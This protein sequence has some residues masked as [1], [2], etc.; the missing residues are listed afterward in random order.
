MTAQSVEMF[1][2]LHD[3][4]ETGGGKN[5]QITLSKDMEDL[6]DEIKKVAPDVYASI[7]EIVIDGLY[8]LKLHQ[9]KK[10]E[11][12]RTEI[13]KGADEIAAGQYCTGDEFR[14]WMRDL[15]SG[16]A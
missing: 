1:D 4:L 7:D 14:K 8:V 11:Q 15:R 2:Q 6:I 3:I 9:G 12:L 13:R 16:N 10:L 5:M